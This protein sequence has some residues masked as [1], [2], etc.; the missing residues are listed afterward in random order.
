[1]T[2][3]SAPFTIR[4]TERT[5]TL[6]RGE[7]VL[8]ET[9]RLLPGYGA[10]PGEA[11]QAAIE[12]IAHDDPR[13]DDIDPSNDP[14]GIFETELMMALDDVA[15]RFEVFEGD[16]AEIGEDMTPLAVDGDLRDDLPVRSIDTLIPAA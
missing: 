9:V 5:P 6:F 10:T 15:G 3:F 4:H 13:L 2:G 14:D 8:L 11:I 1:M 7:K 12:E 16:L